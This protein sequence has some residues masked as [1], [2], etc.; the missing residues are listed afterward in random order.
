[1]TGP[2]PP[3]R[4]RPMAPVDDLRNE[5]RQALKR[6]LAS[7]DRTAVAALRSAIAALDNAEAVPAARRART[8]LAGGVPGAADVPRRALSDEEAQAILQS[9]ISE[10]HVAADEYERLGRPDAAARLRREAAV[11][12]TH[13]SA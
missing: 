3:Y 8:A 11:L 6:A 7:R 9:Q 13:V 2:G 10:R 5:L 1:M 12:L 4:G